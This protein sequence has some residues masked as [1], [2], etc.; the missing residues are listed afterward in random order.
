[1]EQ[2]LTMISL[3]VDNMPASRAF[4]ER[5]GWVANTAASNDDITFF[6]MGGIIMGLYGREALAAEAKLDVGTGFG[7][8]AIAHN[9]RT[10]AEVDAVLALAEKA[11]AKILKPGE[12]V[13]WGGYSGYFQDPD[14]HVWEVAH[15][16]FLPIADDGSVHLPK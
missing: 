8:M 3:G 2:R 15:N 5:L 11:G 7:G 6:Q 13:F 12:K 1:M 16:P 14:G 4:Y 10:E 9:T